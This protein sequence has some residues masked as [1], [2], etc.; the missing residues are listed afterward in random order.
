PAGRGGLPDDDAVTGGDGASGLLDGAVDDVADQPGRSAQGQ[1]CGEPAL[2]LP[3]GAALGDDRG[4]SD[5]LTIQA[6]VEFAAA[7]E[8]HLV[9]VLDRGEVDQAAAE[10]AGA[11]A[12]DRP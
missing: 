4:Q 9:G 2:S 12:Q 5:G 8:E 7:A 3:G 1:R 6:L 10:G 11:G